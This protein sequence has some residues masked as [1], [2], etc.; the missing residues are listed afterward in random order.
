MA[1]ATISKKI[2][3]SGPQCRVC[4]GAKLVKGICPTC[5]R[6][7]PEGSARVDWTQPGSLPPAL[8]MFYDVIA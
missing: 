1:V 3:Q 6:A 2:R 7:Y 8:Q 4:D 5:D